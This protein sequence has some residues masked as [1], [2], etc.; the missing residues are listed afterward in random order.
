MSTNNKINKYRKIIKASCISFIV[1]FIVTAGI[2]LGIGAD[3]AITN[4]KNEP[5][6]V[7][8][9]YLENSE[10]YQTY[11]K[12][13]SDELYHDL[14]NKKID[15]S[16]FSKKFEKLT[17][18]E[19]FIDWARTLDNP[20]VKQVINNYDKKMEQLKNRQDVEA[21]AALLSIT[22]GVSS[23]TISEITAIKVI[24]LKEE[25]ACK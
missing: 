18:D 14:Y 21:T 8:L 23:L 7:Q 16:A 24:K 15:R 10:E 9:K 6:D 25:E 4:L 17:S 3:S 2:T 12:E 11:I 13:K 5:L 22:T 1:S 20:E 19:S